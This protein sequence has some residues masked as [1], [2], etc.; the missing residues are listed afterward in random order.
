MK[1]KLY[2]NYLT[3]LFGANPNQLYVKHYNSYSTKINQSL[4]K[5]EREKFGGHT[6][7][8]QNHYCYYRAVA[9]HLPSF[10]SGIKHAIE[11]ECKGNSACQ[12]RLSAV[13]R[14]LQSDLPKVKKMRDDFQKK[15]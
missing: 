15:I 10:I 5:C 3:E 2:K 6:T 7:K 12:N 11:V 1:E 8:E 14:G 9:K 4:H 13:L